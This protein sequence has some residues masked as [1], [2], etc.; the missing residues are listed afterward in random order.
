MNANRRTNFTYLHFTGILFATG[1]LFLSSLAFTAH[2]SV[3]RNLQD[4]QPTPPAEPPAVD[5]SAPPPPTPTPAPLPAPTLPGSQPTDGSAIPIDPTI[6]VNQP[7]KASVTPTQ[8]DKPGSEFFTRAVATLKS[9]KAIT[10]HIK[11]SGTGGM[12]TYSA[13]VQADVKMLRDPSASGTTNGW[14][15]RSTGSGIARPGADDI[16]FDV[17]WIGNTVEFV[18][19]SD[20]KVIEKRNARDAKSPAFAV[21]ASARFTEFFA[22]RPFSRELVPNAEYAMEGKDTINGVECDIVTVTFGEKKGKSKWAFA[23]SDGLPRR[24]ESFIDNMMMS[25]T[26][27]IEI[28]SLTVDSSDTPRLSKSL[29]RVEVPANYTE[30]RPIKAAPA[31]AK[32]TVTPQPETKPEFIPETKPDAASDGIDETPAD[33]KST[34]DQTSPDPS[35]SQQGA[36]INEDPAKPTIEPLTIAPLFDL[37]ASTGGT[38]S[39]ASL[40]GNAIVIEFGGSWCLPLRESHSEL[41]TLIAHY[42]DKPLRV[43]SLSVRDKSP[44]A[45]IESFNNKSHTFPLLIEADAVAR[46]YR[47]T[48]YPT[49]FVVGANREI[50]KVINTFNKET[51]MTDIKLVLDTYFEYLTG[52]ASQVPAP[53]L[54]PGPSDTLLNPDN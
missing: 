35:T 17:A 6:K 43:V 32:P 12:E 27:V 47:V 33:V 54:A 29:V 11:Y 46:E 9:A 42:K 45:A 26:T 22:G 15:V 36:P 20:K 14:I 25:G 28:N 19:H 23:V 18:S 5:P 8:N 7:P 37:K 3:L 38:L 2:A 40:A 39:L 41:D 53:T 49:Y 30:D 44:A 31:A 52:S 10:Y 51:T 1:S 48:T 34:P 50:L 4:S 16:N 13:K 24:Y 21:A